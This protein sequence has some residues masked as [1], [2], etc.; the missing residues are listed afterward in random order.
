MA[1]AKL[2][3]TW[4]R[5]ATN[6]STTQQKN[7]PRQVCSPV[8]NAIRQ[9]PW[10]AATTKY[11]R[12][13]ASTLYTALSERRLSSSIWGIYMGKGIRTMGL[14]PGPLT[15]LTLGEAEVASSRRVVLKN[16][17]ARS[18]SSRL[19]ILGAEELA[20]CERGGLRD[21]LPILVRHE[22]SVRRRG[23]C[24]LSARGHSEAATSREA[25]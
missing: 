10:R 2:Y 14:Y 19:G 15:R 21:C 13:T 5:S 20:P 7:I 25:Y 4:H 23:S 24:C 6:T 16:V 12:S 1:R 9:R 18:I 17:A 11:N 22:R 8:L 3:S